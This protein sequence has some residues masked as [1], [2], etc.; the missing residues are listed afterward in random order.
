MKRFK[1]LSI[2]H[3]IWGGYL[4]FMVLLMGASLYLGGLS[5]YT[6]NLRAS[7]CV[8]EPFKGDACDSWIIVFSILMVV[9]LVS[10]TV[11]NLLAAWAYNPPSARQNV[12]QKI[13][14][15]S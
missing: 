3:Y 4:L 1:W 12:V 14:N 9:F 5:R 15:F 13:T 11:V 7:L 2:F 10:F 6:T 8:N